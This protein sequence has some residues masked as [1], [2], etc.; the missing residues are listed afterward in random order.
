MTIRLR[1]SLA[2]YR[3]VARSPSYFPLWVSQLL[4]SFGDTLHSIALG[5][6]LS[7]GSISG[8]R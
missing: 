7:G 5:L 6:A 8:G 3:D 1:A 2:S 4:S